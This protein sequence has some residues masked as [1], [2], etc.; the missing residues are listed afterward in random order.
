MAV[1]SYWKAA[2]Q[3]HVS[4][5]DYLGYCQFYFCGFGGGCHALGVDPCPAL[6][7]KASRVRLL[8]LIIVASETECCV[9]F[10]SLV[11][12]ILE[13]APVYVL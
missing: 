6:P 12:C 13:I 8:M 1:R 7:V 10:C 4:K 5:G 9:I 2:W 11:L 3:A